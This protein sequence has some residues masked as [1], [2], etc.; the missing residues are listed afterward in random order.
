MTSNCAGLPAGCTVD[1]NTGFDVASFLL[2]LTSQKVR[3][4]SGLT[5]AGD[6][7]TYMERRPE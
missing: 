5:S 6:V 2:G 1:S 7:E 3:A 4:L